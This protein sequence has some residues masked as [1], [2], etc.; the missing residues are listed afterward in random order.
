MIN[1]DEAPPPTAKEV[2]GVQRNAFVQ[3]GLVFGELSAAEYYDEKAIIAV[4]T[5]LLA[6]ATQ[7]HWAYLAMLDDLEEGEYNVTLH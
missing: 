7:M 2:F 5:A 4:R 6:T 3:L 1:D